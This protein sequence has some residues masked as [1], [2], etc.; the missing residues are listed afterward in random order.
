MTNDEKK[1]KKEKKKK[2]VKQQKNSTI[3]IRNEKIK[4]FNRVRHH[5]RQFALAYVYRVLSKS[6]PRRFRVTR[7]VDASCS[8]RVRVVSMSCRYRVGVVFVTS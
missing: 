8:S 5:S 2:K 1:R 3:M 4:L 7:V 6:F